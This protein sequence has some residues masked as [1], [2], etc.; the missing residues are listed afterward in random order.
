MHFRAAALRCRRKKKNLV[1]SLE[2]KVAEL[3]RVNDAL[4]VNAV[5]CHCR[6]LSSTHSVLYVV[7]RTASE[8]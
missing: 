6:Q 3:Q 8:H 1:A 4:E 7:Q 5:C 2:N